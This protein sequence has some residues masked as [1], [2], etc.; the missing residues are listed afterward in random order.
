MSKTK[1]A[2]LEKE[3]AELRLKKHDI[4]QAINFERSKTLVQCVSNNYGKGCG[5][6]TQIRKLDYI[7][8]HWYTPPRG[9]SGGDYWSEGEGQFVCPKCNHRNRLYGFPE[10][11][12]MQTLFKTITDCYDRN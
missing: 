1:I 10:I 5:V 7:R 8:T 2:Q 11:E 3:L 9:C 12:K 6:K 4:N